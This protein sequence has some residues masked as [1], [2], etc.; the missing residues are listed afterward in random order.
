[1]AAEVI[2]DDINAVVATSREKKDKPKAPSF[3]SDNQAEKDEYFRK[4][5]LNPLSFDDLTR[6]DGDFAKL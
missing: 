4:L 5:Y 6:R 3:L 2:L 1:M